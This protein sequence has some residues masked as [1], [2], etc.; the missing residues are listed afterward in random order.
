[1]KL[2]ELPTIVPKIVELDGRSKAS[3]NKLSNNLD[4]T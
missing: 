3:E 4:K 1:M 2:I